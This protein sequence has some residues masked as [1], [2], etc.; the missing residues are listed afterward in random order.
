MYCMIKMSFFF[1]TIVLLSAI[2]CSSWHT[3]THSMKWVEAAVE[4]EGISLIITVLHLFYCLISAGAFSAICYIW[5]EVIDWIWTGL[6]AACSLGSCF[7][8]RNNGSD[9]ITRCDTDLII[10]SPWAKEHQQDF[11]WQPVEVLDMALGITS[12]DVTVI[13]K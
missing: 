13:I 1:I 9:F 11:Y 5:P 3:H 4:E 7:L 2:V 6:G 12:I 8:H 10:W